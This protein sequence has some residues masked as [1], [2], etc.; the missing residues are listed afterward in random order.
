MRTYNQIIDTLQEFTNKHLILRSFGNGTITELNS[1]VQNNSE[2]PLLWASLQDITIQG[3]EVAYFFQIQCLDTRMKD[4]N[5][6]RDLHSD[7]AQCLIDLRQYLIHN[8]ETNSIFTF[9]SQIMRMTPVVN[10][11]NDWLSGMMASFK[12]STVIVQSDCQIP[13]ES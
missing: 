10:S 9:D 11:T 8:W 4:R 13:I 7:T 5:N 12:I 1:F 2:Q 6:L 3:N